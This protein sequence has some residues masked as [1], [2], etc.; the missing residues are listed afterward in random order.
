MLQGGGNSRGRRRLKED[1]N[2]GEAPAE[3]HLQLPGRD[4]GT[5]EL[6]T[7][8]EKYFTKSLLQGQW[9]FS[10]KALKITQGR[11]AGERGKIFVGPILMCFVFIRK[12]F[13]LP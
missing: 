3:H 8:V 6:V 10:P 13:P 11:S 9:M 2:C 5:G 12:Y 1:S 7:F 4:V